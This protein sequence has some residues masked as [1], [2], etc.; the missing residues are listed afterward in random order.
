MQQPPAAQHRF[1]L[2]DVNDPRERNAFDERRTDR[3]PEA[4]DHPPLRRMVEDAAPH[5][6]DG[7]ERRRRTGGA[8]VLIAAAQRA[9]GAGRTEDVVGSAPEL[10][11]VP[12]PVKMEPNLVVEFYSS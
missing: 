8:D 6:I 7:H 5:G 1:H 2:A 9:A 11:E 10:A 12:Y 3:G 4:G